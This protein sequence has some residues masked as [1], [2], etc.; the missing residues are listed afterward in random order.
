MICV[1]PQPEAG[2]D[3]VLPV[4]KAIAVAATFCFIQFR[5]CQK[6]VLVTSR[7]LWSEI[8]KQFRPVVDRS[9]A[10][11]IEREPGIIRP[12]GRPSKSVSGGVTVKVEINASDGTRH[13]KA[14]TI[15]VN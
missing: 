11:A 15:D 6:S 8:A 4:N 14:I 9:I 3:G 13:G 10:I 5:Q 2:K 12:C 7:R 1:L